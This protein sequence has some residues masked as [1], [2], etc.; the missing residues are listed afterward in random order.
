MRT[1]F[2]FDEEQQTTTL[3]IVSW[4]T[5]SVRTNVLG[6]RDYIFFVTFSDRPT[7]RMI[8]PMI[9]FGAR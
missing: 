2:F 7:C 4:V 9:S 6:F 1:V 3:K 5:V 8:R